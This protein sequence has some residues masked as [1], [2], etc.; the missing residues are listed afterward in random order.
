MLTIAKVERSGV[1][2]RFV[3]INA[4]SLTYWLRFILNLVV[5]GAGGPATVALLKGG[6]VKTAPGL[7]TT[8]G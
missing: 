4:D 5:V 2:L 6:H 1:F 8:R 3:S 7:A